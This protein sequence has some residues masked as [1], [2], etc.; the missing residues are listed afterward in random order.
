MPSHRLVAVMGVVLAMF[1]GCKSEK[2]T[3][4][5]WV[6]CTCPYLTDYDE[7]AKHTLRVCV[8]DGENAEETAFGCA[9]KLVHGPAE[10]CRCDPPAEVCDSPKACISNEYK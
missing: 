8:P 4:G 6:A 5:R 2:S 10:A 7:P 9:S 3:S 1:C